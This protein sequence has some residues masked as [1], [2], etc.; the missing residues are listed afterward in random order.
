[1]DFR[2]TAIVKMRVLTALC[3]TGTS[4]YGVPPPGFH[5]PAGLMV[6]GMLC[7][8]IKKTFEKKSTYDL[9]YAMHNYSQFIRFIEFPVW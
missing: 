5:L 2:V 6:S 9:P 4:G 1:M 8:V 3:I 7:E